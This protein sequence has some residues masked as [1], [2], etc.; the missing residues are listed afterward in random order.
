MTYKA[1]HPRRAYQTASVVMSEASVRLRPLQ[2]MLMIL[3]LSAGSAV[4]DSGLKKVFIVHSYEIDHVCGRPQ[5][6]GVVRALKDAGFDESRV[7]Y[8]V[9]AMDTKRRFNTPE[10]IE[11]QAAI[12]LAQ[13]EEFGPDVV[14]TLDDN[15]FRTV[16]LAVAE[17]DIPVVFSGLNGRP[18]GYVTTPAWIQTREQPGGNITGVI[19]KIH[20]VTAVR[21]QKNIIPSLRR[22]L[23]LSDNSPTG[24]ALTAQI[25]EELASEELPVEIEFFITDSWE[26]YQQAVLD[27]PNTGS[28]TLYPVAL[29]LKDASGATY[30]AKEILSWTGQHS[31]LPSIPLNFAFGK[32]GLFGGAGVDFHGMGLQAG[33]MVARV[34]S[35]QSV[36]SVPIED[37]QRY[38]LVFHLKRA[39]ALG[40]AIPDDILMAA[41]EVYRD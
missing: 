16:A 40:I 14:V 2:Y 6:D 19:E 23:V 5:H 20:F 15:A 30:T 36:G 26:E 10:Q 3:L 29:R 17:K 1:F 21:V 32:L 13:I 8:G 24:K 31:K 27:A 39:E 34:L 37:A 28:D 9:Y 18:E 7:S 4:A 22:V 25:R 33:Q 38:A 11:A 41:D 35:G 12:A